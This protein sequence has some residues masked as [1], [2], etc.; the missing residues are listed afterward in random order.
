M[1]C[2]ANQRDEIAEKRE[3]ETCGIPK[4]RDEATMLSALLNSTIAIPSDGLTLFHF[5]PDFEMQILSRVE[6]MKNLIEHLCQFKV[7][8]VFVCSWIF[9]VLP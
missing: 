5:L 6:K 7:E 9:F 8:D 3:W 2:T 1:K 4:N